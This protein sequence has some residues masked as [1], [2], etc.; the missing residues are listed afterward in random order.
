MERHHL[1]QV[2]HSR[3]AVA[4]DKHLAVA[5]DSH[6]VIVAN[7]YLA[8]SHSEAAD[9]RSEVVVDNCLAALDVVEYTTQF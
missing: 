1:W 2:G 9:M 8:E 4:V 6:L 3:L 7:N 5:A